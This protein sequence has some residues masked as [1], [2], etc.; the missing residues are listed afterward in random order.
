MGNKIC[1]HPRVL[2]TDK[3]A[4]NFKSAN[5][6]RDV[7][8]I[9]ADWRKA[10]ADLAFSIKEFEETFSVVSDLEQQFN[11]F[12]TDRNGRVDAHEVFMVIILLASGAMETKID[13]VFSIFDFP[14]G[15]T[16]EKHT[17]NFEE[18]SMLLRACVNSL[19]KVCTLDFHIED[20][21]LNFYSKSMFDMHHLSYDERI[22]KQRF[23]EWC[24]TDPSPRSF[25]QLFHHSQGLPDIYAQVQ[26]KNVEQG[27]VFQMLA[28]G[29]LKLSC[30]ALLSSPQFHRVVGSPTQASLKVLVDLMA[31]DEDLSQVTNER[32]HSVLRPW[33]IFN[34]CDLD[35]SGS[36]DDKELEVLLWIQMRKKP[37]RNFVRDFM[38]SIDSDGSG[39]VSRE[40]WVEAIAGVDRSRKA[41]QKQVSDASSEVSF[42][43]GA[44][45]KNRS[46][47]IAKNRISQA[48]RASDNDKQELMFNQMITAA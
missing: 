36:L 20:D 14:G 7:F 40:E 39:E 28:K 15:R 17:I 21:E 9:I 44:S 8:P 38:K 19:A 29:K 11:T 32:F 5:L 27:M 31:S 13:T 45:G 10:G 47:A 48:R 43:D 23:Q 6:V 34:E 42:G 41:M 2:L 25:V 30:E 1:F 18:A 37:T 46:S 35:G 33:N 3:I 12:D 4:L 26:Q 16:V 22:S 24:V